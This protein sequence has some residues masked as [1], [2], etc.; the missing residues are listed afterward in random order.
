MKLSRSSAW[1][2]LLWLVLGWRDAVADPL[3]T[4]LTRSAANSPGWVLPPAPAREFRAAWIPT[5]GNSCWPS[6]PG[7]STAQQKAEL[8]A[9]LDR[10]VALHLNAVI[11]Q[12][13]PSCDALYASDC[14]PWS[15][16]LTGV[17]G[18]AP[19]PY[20]DP[21]A[22]AVTEAHRRGLELHAWF[23]PFRAHHHQAVSPISANHISRQHPAW[24]RSYGKYLWLDPGDPAVRAYSRRVVLDVVRRYDLDGVHFDDYFYPYREP[25]P[26]GQPLDFPDAATWQRYGPASHL[27]RDDW[28]RQNVDQFI[29][30][31]YSGIKELKPWVKFGISPFGIW[32]PQNPPG[33]TGLDAY[34]VLYAD[35]RQWL[36][37]G[38]CDY[39]T[40]Q[41]Y[42]STTSTG[43]NFAA[44]LGWWNRQNTL[45]RHLWPGLNDLKTLEGWPVREIDAELNLTRRLADPGAVHWSLSAPLRNPALAAELASG[46]YHQFALVPASPWLGAALPAA[47]DLQVRPRAGG[48]LA[49]WEPG[50]GVP[51]RW[52]LLQTRAHGEW[53]AHLLPA[54]QT[55]TRL[56]TLDTHPDGVVVRAVSRTGVLGLPAWWHR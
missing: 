56:D 25:G 10:A 48:L 44:L 33:V 54:D 3:S 14:E 9:L 4:P 21:L 43:Q 37:Q 20:Y 12:V 16:Y 51:T 45:H 30:S 41:L 55:L 40:P 34:N 52:W 53:S 24:V 18:R 39:L 19:A 22:L 28:R 36:R 47:P 35:S 6:K 8:I 2:L 49:E 5:V 31:T 32:R 50:A 42:W 17:M 7:L 29:Q 27:A 46:S 23:N 26:G 15:E 38:W 13:R 11:F 1:L